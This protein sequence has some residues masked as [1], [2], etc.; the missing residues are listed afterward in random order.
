MSTQNVIPG[1]P[2]LVLAGSNAAVT[3]PGDGS[4]SGPVPAGSIQYDWLVDGVPF[5]IFP[6]EDDPYM[7]DLQEDVKDQFDSSKEAGEQSFGY[8][9]LRSQSSYHA[10]AGQVYLDTSGEDIARNRFFSSNYLDPFTVQGQ[11]TVNNAFNVQ[12][13][14]RKASALVTWS[15]VAKLATASSSDNKVYIAD[16]PDLD[17]GTNV[18]L[19]ATGTCQ[20]MCTDGENLYVAI[21]DSVYRINASATATKIATV[22]FVGPVTI[23]FAKA[24]VIL[25]TGPQVYE[26]DPAPAAPP[27]A[28]TSAETVYIHP[29]DNWRYT[30]IA[31]GP[32]GIYLAGYLGPLSE[33]SLMTVQD[34]GTGLELSQ[35]VVQLRTPP[36]E[37]INGVAFYLNSFFGLATSNGI[38]VGQFTPYGQP[39]YGPVLNPGNAVYS[40]TGSG[41]LLYFGGVNRVWS[42]DLGTQIAEGRYAYCQY[43]DDINPV[44][45]TDNVL[46]IE[47]AVVSHEDRLFGVQ[48]SGGIYYQPSD[49]ASPTFGQLI[50]SWARFGTVEP[51]RLHYIRLEGTF[52]TVGSGQTNTVT[53]ETIDGDSRTFTI[54]GARTFFEFGVTDF[55]SSEAYRLVFSLV[56]DTILRSWQLKSRP[57][58]LQYQQLILP[59]GCW[60]WE[61]SADGQTIGYDGWAIARLLQVEEA[62][63]SNRIVT[64]V[65]KWANTQYRAQIARC[66]FRQTVQPGSVRRIGGKVTLILRLI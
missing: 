52:P 2:P 48:A 19:G 15:G 39:Q 41:S 62:A 56:P 10:G 27:T 6:T 24:R 38:R 14:A 35:P 29:S 9:W 37:I 18:T 60:D 54:P 3:D 45:S 65:D 46:T 59:L 23:G 64:V 21:A 44:S 43:G 66:Q 12:N 50:T 20:A 53:V 33:L 17:N 22:T 8:W 49:P 16:V 63:R 47:V 31:D 61:E 7:R 42:V 30:A 51:K 34:V 28:Y 40:V 57:A 55:P 25:T 58:P 1:V 11:V 36:S 5:L 13:V 26:I 32:N 4:N